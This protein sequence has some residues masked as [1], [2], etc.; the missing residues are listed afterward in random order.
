MDAHEH[1]EPQSPLVTVTEAARLLNKSRST[2][3]NWVD[4]GKFPSYCRPFTLTDT[5]TRT[6]YFRR[7]EL[8]RFIDEAAEQNRIA[9]K[10]KK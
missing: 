7:D 4:E 8:L 2:I 6:F 5:G 10:E 3:H 9:P 1:D